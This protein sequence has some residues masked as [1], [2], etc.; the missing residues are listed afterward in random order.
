MVRTFLAP[1]VG[2]IVG[3]GAILG[4]QMLGHFLFPPPDGLDLTTPGALAA[5]MAQIPPEALVAV[6]ASY[7]LGSFLGVWAALRVHP[8]HARWP[9]ILTVLVLAAGAAYTIATI[10]HPIWFIVL[11]VV[12]F[13]LAMGAATQAVPALDPDGYDDE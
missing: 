13:F 12:V 9:G 1:L 6:L 4:L 10:P 3:V 5:Y 2:L 8:S 11:A 7:F